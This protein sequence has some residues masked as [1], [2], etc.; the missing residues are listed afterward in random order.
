MATVQTIKNAVTSAVQG[1][2]DGIH[3]GNQVVGAARAVDSFM[4]NQAPRGGRVGAA[5]EGY[6]GGQRADA[7]RQ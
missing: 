2:R 1:G 6:A 5:I 7:L 3:A 4:T